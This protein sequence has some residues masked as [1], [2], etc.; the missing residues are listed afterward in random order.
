MVVSVTRAVLLGVLATAA[1]TRDVSI[2]AELPLAASGG[3]LSTGGGGAGGEPFDSSA[4]GQTD[5][6]VEAYCQGRLYDCGDCRDNDVDGFVD[7][8]D[9]D[10]LGPC[11]NAE[12][13]FYTI[14]GQSGVS[15]SQ[16]CYFDQDRGVGNDGCAA[17]HVCD[18]LAPEGPRCPYTPAARECVDRQP[19]SPLC[20]AECGPLTPNGC[21]CFGCCSIPGA[22]T[23]VWVGSVDETGS[24][25]CDRASLGDPSRC[26]PCTQDPSCLNP[27]EPCELCVGKT[28][29]PAECS[30][31]GCTPPACSR[32]R[33]ACGLPCLPRCPSGT[34]CI[35]GCCI[36]EIR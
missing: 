35:T 10:C 29:L 14:P 12:D 28:T 33:Q 7:S 19:Q 27:C 5:E 34:S 26:H 25:S 30:D 20:V 31:S 11:H 2:G 18:P 36:E 17:S 23:P 6:C 8:D 32:N 16:E 9:P 15:C 3:A 13:T 1:C 4:G 24:P 22:P 21:D